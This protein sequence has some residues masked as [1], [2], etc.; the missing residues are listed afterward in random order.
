M[1]WDDNGLPTERRVQ[2]FFGVR[3]DPSRLRPRLRAP[4]AQPGKEQIPISRPNFVAAV[5]R[6]TGEDERVFEDLFRRLG[7]LGRLDPDLH[8]HRGPAGARRQRA[9][10][11]NLARGEAYQREAPTLWDVDFRTAV[12]QAELEDR[13]VPGAYHTLAF[14]GPD[15]DLCIDTTRPE[16]LVGLRGDGRPPRRRPVPGAV[17]HHG[18]T[19][20]FGVEVPVLAHPLAEPEKGTGVAMVC[21]FGDTADVMWWRELELPARPSSAGTGG[22]LTGDAGVDHR[23]RGSRRYERAGRHHHEAGPG[24]LVELL[25]ETGELLGEP[26]PITH[27]VKFYEKGDRPLE[28]VTTRQ[29]YI[30][31]G[32]RDATLREACWTRGE[33]LGWHPDYMRHR[34]ENWVEGLTGDWLISRQ[35]FFGVPIPLWYPL[36]PDGAA[37]FDHPI[38]P[39]EE[40]LPIDPSID[41]P[42]GYADDQRGKP[43]GFLG[44]PDVMDTWATSSLTPQIAGR[45]EDDADLFAR[46]FP[47]DLRPQGPRHHP[48]LAVRHRRAGEL[49]GRRAAVVERGHLRLDP[50]PRPQEDVEVE[51]QRRHTDVAARAVRVRRR[52]LLGDLGSARGRHRVRRGADEDRAQARHQAAQRHQVRRSASAMP[53][54]ERS[55]SAVA[56]P[57][58][59]AMLAGWPTLS[60]PKPPRPSTTTTTPARWSAPKRSSGG[61]A[62]TTSSWSRAGPTAD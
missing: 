16:L 56:E 28:I 7:A 22:W 27:P 8:D 59:R 25:R 36:G 54:R 20:L 58:D 48:H 34:Y 14:H 10:L 21:T 47:M 39:P 45:W 24:P 19:P 61:S 12:A 38:A 3:C 11:R 6:L 26:R 57:V 52:P 51:G 30:R 50:R 62:T 1:G 49:R 46:V 5:R 29:W 13:D 4:R 23:G 41:V 2:N 31:N 55:T 37:D 15:G 60:S 17:R 42:P 53:R 43:G 18:T 9:F 32:G 35:R 44:E 40:A 33:E